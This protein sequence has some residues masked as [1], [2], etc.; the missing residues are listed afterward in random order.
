MNEGAARNTL[1]LRAW[2][3]QVP[4]PAHW[5]DEDRAWASSAAAAVEGERAPPDDYI[6]RRSALAVERLAS[7]EPKLQRILAAVT[8]RPWVGWALAQVALLAGLASDAVSAD[9]QINI[10][11]PPLLALLAWNLTV[12]L[13]LAARVIWRVTGRRARSTGPFARTLA[14]LAHGRALPGQVTGPVAGFL[15]DWAR[16]GSTLTAARVAR[17]LHV[18][19]VAF[20]LGALSAWYVRGLALEYRAGWESTFLDAQSVH[21]LLSVVLGPAARITGIGI[22]DEAR[23]AAIR[24]SAGSGENAAPWIHLYAVTVALLVLLPRSLLALAAR[25]RESRLT[26]RFPLP[27]DD[28]YFQRLARA[29]R[30][31]AAVVHML[32]YSIQLAPQTI[33]ALNRLLTRVFGSDC[34]LE[35][36]RV[37]EFGGEDALGDD[38]LPKRPAALVVALFALTATPEP[39]NQ[40]AFVTALAR[41]I[42][43]ATP[44]LVMVEE[45]TFRERFAREPARLDERRAAWQRMLGAIGQEPVFL[46][47]GQSDPSQAERALHTALDRAARAGAG[48]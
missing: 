7:R 41:R 14:R 33:L 1:L 37:T 3:T 45:S 6:A 43:S 48:A 28:A 5:T 47:L 15:H 18:A 4:A 16:A 20:A 30:G 40:G 17:V 19:A 8:W 35:I 11:A 10:L 38:L 2:E 24:F 39:E 46:N 23:L 22:P 27:L 26:A 25:W 13:A 34:Q 9:K 21:S 29:H 36:A 44:F 42:S 12:Y 31:E 32:P